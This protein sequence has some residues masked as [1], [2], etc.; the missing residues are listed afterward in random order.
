M[1]ELSTGLMK[2]LSTAVVFFLLFKVTCQHWAIV[3][4]P[5]THLYQTVLHKRGRRKEV[6]KRFTTRLR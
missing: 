1:V 4:L 2:K 3:V 6:K 5:I